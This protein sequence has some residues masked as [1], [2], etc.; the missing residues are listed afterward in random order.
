MENPGKA[1]Q[2][3]RLTLAYT[4]S[5]REVIDSLNLA[6]LPRH[7]ACIMDGNGRWAKKQMKERLFG[8]QSA[9][10]TVRTIVE[11]CRDIGIEVLTLFAFSS[12]NWRRPQLE[13]LGLMRLL[14]Q[15]LVEERE[16]LHRNSIR[17]K[18]IGEREAL[19]PDVRE[20]IRISE[21]LMAPNKGM[22]LN[23]AINYGGRQDLVRAICQIARNVKAGNLEESSITEDLVSRSLSTA[24][25]PEPDLLIRTA[26]EF[27]V[28]NFLL[29]EIAY[30]EI[31]ISPRL[32]P[33][34]SRLELLETIREYQGR[35]R[36]FGGL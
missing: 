8:H 29:W 1:G 14:R 34:F 3:S 26:G 9:R 16:D 24:G 4:A 22:V 17:L 23:L 36:R 5:E 27:R 7:I 15:T 32:W 12:E 35:Q 20:E 25:L 18:V 31:S 30:T 11:T 33:E 21:E 28:S 2:P 13:V 19:P 10:T 6:A